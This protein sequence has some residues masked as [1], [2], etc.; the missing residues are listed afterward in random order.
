[1]AALT[2]CPFLFPTPVLQ[3]SPL[4]VDFGQADDEESFTVSNTGSGLLTWTVEEVT[5]EEDGQAGETWAPTELT[6]LTV[7]PAS[8]T[9]T[10]VMSRVTLTA[11][12]TGLPAGVISGTGVRVVSNGGTTVVRVSLTVRSK[13][14]VSPTELGLA[15]DA[16][17]AEFSIHNMDTVSRT[18]RVQCLSDP[19]DV[20]SVTDFPSW[21]TVSPTNGALQAGAQVVVRLTFTGEPQDFA[22]LVTSGT[23]VTV[24]QV[25]F[26]EMNLVATPSP[27][28]LYGLGSSATLTIQN[29]GDQAVS[30]QIVLRNLTDLTTN[31]PVTVATPV[32]TTAAGEESDVLITADAEDTGDI[33]FGEGPYVLL[34]QTQDAV[35]TIPIRIEVVNLPEILVSQPPDVQN[36]FPPPVST[37]EL[38]LGDSAYQGEFYIANGGP[39]ASVLYFVITHED[40]EEPDPL[41]ESVLIDSVAVNQ[42]S[43]DKDEDVFYLAARGDWIYGVPI[44]VVVNRNNMQDAVEYRTITI[45]AWDSAFQHPLD[46]V[47]PVE[48][49]VRVERPPIRFEG[50]QHRS[51]PPFM[52][53][54]VFLLRDSL[55]EAIDT[56]DPAIFAEVADGLTVYEDDAPLTEETNYYVTYAENLRY[57][58]VMLLDYTGSMR[59]K[60]REEGLY[61]NS[62][63]PLREMYSGAIGESGSEGLVGAFVRDLPASYQLA[64]MEFHYRQQSSRVIYPFSTDDVSLIGA[65]KG[66]ALPDGA[67]GVSELYDALAEACQV[68]A[69]KDAGA[70]PFITDA[71]VRAIVFLSDGKDTSST[72]GSA[73]VISLAQEL[74]I[75]LYPIAFGEDAN[76]VPLI[77][78]AAETGGHFYQAKTVSGTGRETLEALLVRDPVSVGTNEPGRIVSELERQIVLTYISPI[79][80]ESGGHS[81]RLRVDYRGEFG[82]TGSDVRAD[83]NLM[84]SGDVHAGQISLATSGIS[85]GTAEVYVRAEY[86]PRDVSQFRFRIVTD[87][88]LAL[89][90]DNVALTGLLVNDDGT[91]SWRM[92]P[93]GGNIFLLVTD[94]TGYLPYGS[95]GNLLRI[96]FENVTQ[97]FEVG[98]RS[99]N[100]IY[101]PPSNAF[102]QCPLENLHVGSEPDVAAVAKDDIILI[103]DQF[104]PSAPGAFDADHDGTRDFDDPKP[105]DPSYPPPFA[106][107]TT[108]DFG[109]DQTT[110][111]LTL[112]NR[113]FDDLTWRV[114]NAATWLTVSPTSDTLAVGQQGST[115]ITANRAGLTPGVHSDTFSFELCPVDGA[116]VERLVVHVSITVPASL[117]VAPTQVALPAS[118]NAAVLLISN[119]GAEAF[120]WTIEAVSSSYPYQVIPLPETLTISSAV[121][122][123]A[124]G[125]PTSVTVSADRA[126]LAV[127]TYSYMLRV[128]TSPDVGSQ[129]VPVDLVVAG[130]PNLVVDEGDELWMLTGQRTASLTLRNTGD[131]IL[132][133]SI[134][135][136]HTPEQGPSLPVEMMPIQVAPASG[137]IPAATQDTEPQPAPVTITVDQPALLELLGEGRHRFQILIAWDRG[138]ENVWFY[139]DLA[140]MPVAWV[141]RTTL[142]F[143]ADPNVFEMTFLVGN[144]GAISSKLHYAFEV[145]GED[146][147]NTPLITMIYND[148]ESSTGI[149]WRTDPDPVPY[150]EHEIT[151]SID[152]SVLNEQVEYRTI[153]V[154]DTEIA[155]VEPVEVRVR[156]EQTPLTIEGAI[157][158]SRPPYILR[159]VFLLRD[160]LGQVIP[161]MTEEDLAKL[162]FVVE[163]NGVVLDPAE[164]NQFVT[165]PQHLKYNLVLLLDYTG[166]MYNAGLN[167]PGEAIAQMV[168]GAKGFID[169]LPEGYRVAVMEYHDRQQGNRLLHGF[170]TNKESLKDAI[171]AFLLPPAEHGASEVFDALAAA[172]DL[173]A[174]EDPEETVPFDDADVRAV[175]FIS[176]GWDTSSVGSQTDVISRAKES[177]VR[178][179]PIGF[180]GGQT[181]NTAALVAL[182]ND[183]GGHVYYAPSADSLANLLAN[184]LGLAL[185]DASVNGLEATFNIC[186]VGDKSL[187]W[188]LDYESGLWLSV[189]LP[190]LGTVPPGQ[191]YLV[192]VTADDTGLPPGVY[193]Q[194]VRISA[195]TTTL[196][197]GT[198]VPVTLNA[199]ATLELN[200]A[201]G[202]PSTLTLKLSDEPGRVWRE[203][204]NQVV[205]TY[206][207]LLQSNAPDYL[208]RATYTLDGN[209]YVGSFRND[210]VYWPGDV[211]QGQVSLYTTGISWDVASGRYGATAYVRTDYVPRNISEFRVRFFVEFTPPEDVPAD[212]QDAMRAGLP[213]INDAAVALAPDGLIASWRLIH[214]GDGVYT[215][216]TEQS[217]ALQYAAFGNLLTVTFA[218]LDAFVAA[219]DGLGV[220]PSFTLG[221]RMDNTLYYSPA[222]PP[223][224]P[225]TT[226]YF[227]Y[228][229]G[230]LNRGR[231][232]TIGMESDTATPARNFLDLTVLGFDPEGPLA[233]D[234]DEDGVSDFDDPDPENEFVPAPFLSVRTLSIGA[235]TNTGTFTIRNARFDT[236]TWSVTAAPSWVVEPIVGQESTPLAPGK[237]T[238]VTVTVDRT[239]LPSG[240]MPPERIAIRV[241]TS[242]AVID[243]PELTVNLNVP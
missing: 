159:F 132:T 106:A 182:A 228:P 212:A 236:V 99:D 9:T 181:L 131:D 113:R 176:D 81:Y 64:L 29:T 218:D 121:G 68:L 160:M 169:D 165:G 141:D 194:E 50:A 6:W 189:D 30:W 44:T 87:P 179:Y 173:L 86:V 130:T 199:S 196:R 139:I 213:S 226:K 206:A 45:K 67:H 33:V 102:M 238:V 147:A 57:D 163:E 172:A 25:T 128:T 114:S 143:G 123:A 126:G 108:V 94:E 135:M 38:D 230:R 214:Q 215:V 242:E 51:R 200:V 41:I 195:E 190:H 69:E 37:T 124:S 93:E 110:A 28:E 180:S 90:A 4:V 167:A 88:T 178:F 105:A 3:V 136:V 149:L 62:P 232:L 52:L 137:T 191:C 12:R 119:V 184:E 145:L 197:G 17:S 80:A 204:R 96:T 48:V 142:D 78:M 39:A 235:T 198:T 233:W 77:A 156:V 95:F 158:R 231:G 186:D 83:D 227:E 144:P 91:S 20:G 183:T 55:G 207:T 27:L 107:P 22:L 217:N 154:K 92:I 89:T 58:V 243:E 42:G 220:D 26:G 8:G 118:V 15:V 192:R 24:V 127:G 129:L 162:D 82:E 203:L 193:A 53:R 187:P 66:F 65:L 175:V 205:L 164:T 16:T 43:T 153:R 60:V 223:G 14:V 210:V 219:F 171:S 71:D 103:E 18:W 11:D 5:L 234:S 116:S 168:E 56:R 174:A 224:S 7:T 208:V 36:T 177:R 125:A 239:G 49:K 76:N 19:S 111:A 120:D 117:Q 151:V 79:A 59:D 211:R 150:P 209:D 10:G 70:E 73:E 202:A 134:T 32:G 225:S 112:T 84:S 152:R 148:Q 140:P 72:A 229:G 54:F 23:E 138:T 75:R 104:D 237:S 74:G 40:E 170:T 2:G 201:Q 34:V 166:S 146:N 241:A 61:P 222:V 122:T 115:T 13:V 188:T 101:G 161:T 1:V 21:L 63:D 109:A 46:A 240:Q 31:V 133:W 185:D 35:L 47:D 155:A 98:I 216:L 100:S 221:F 85:D 97:E 157:N